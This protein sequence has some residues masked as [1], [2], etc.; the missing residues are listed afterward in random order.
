[1]LPYLTLK[2]KPLLTQK[3]KYFS[4]YVKLIRLQH[5]D[6]HK[7]Y[8]ASVQHRNETFIQK[9]LNFLKMIYYDCFHINSKEMCLSQSHTFSPIALL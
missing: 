7:I 6:T 9:S 8:S 5:T 3:L 1:M 4:F 2:L